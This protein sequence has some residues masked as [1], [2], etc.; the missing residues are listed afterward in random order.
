MALVRSWQAVREQARQRKN[1]R[2]YW[3]GTAKNNLDKGNV[4]KSIREDLLILPQRFVYATLSFAGE[5]PS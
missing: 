4:N 3:I 2:K 5:D 1:N